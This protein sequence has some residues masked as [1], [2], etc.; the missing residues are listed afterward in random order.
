MAE[1]TE[2]Y[3]RGRLF[4]G[5]PG[6]IFVWTWVHKAELVV[7]VLAATAAALFA[8]AP[9][10][11]AFLGAAIVL[12]LSIAESE[13][14]LLFAIF[15]M[16]FAWVLQWN[17]P[18]RDVP[19]AFRSLVIVGFFLGRLLRGQLGMKQLLRPALTQASLLFLCVATVSALL[20]IGGL[21]RE[22]A[23]SLWT[24][25]TFVGFYF[26]V[27]S[28]ADSPRRVRRILQVVLF[29]T[30]ITAVFA[31]V[32]EFAGDYTSLWLFLNPPNEF[33]QPMDYR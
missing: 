4:P 18:V 9:W 32:Q 8:F 33:F 20:A 5:A 7:G 22:S 11:I 13:S 10:T 6:D 31:I 28:W 21:T 1:N 15:V 14:F 2:H 24:L 16:P 26:V 3:A 17:V 30:I 25:F 27:L 29:S 12:A 19:V 23:R